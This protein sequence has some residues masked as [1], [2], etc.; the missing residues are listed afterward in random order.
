MENI[1]IS[2]INTKV[3]REPFK[4]FQSLQVLMGQLPICSIFIEKWK[5]LNI[6]KLRKNDGKDLR[7]V[8]AWKWDEIAFKS[9]QN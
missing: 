6:I 3:A 8:A 2:S 7:N 9:M 5:T 4:A 1:N